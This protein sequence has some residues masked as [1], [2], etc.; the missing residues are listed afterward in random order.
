MSLSSCWSLAPLEMVA[1]TASGEEG[2]GSEDEEL[3]PNRDV[4]RYEVLVARANYFAQGRSDMQFSVKEIAGSM[5]APIR[6]SWA[7]LFKLGRYLKPT[8]GQATGILTKTTP[9]S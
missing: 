4:K 3:L 1:S 9:H 2:E 6:G 8:A 5:S 7:C